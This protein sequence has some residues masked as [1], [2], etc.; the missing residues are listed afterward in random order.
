SPSARLYSLVPRSSQCPSMSTSCSGCDLSQPALASRIFASPGRMSYLSKSKLMS[1]SSGMAT[2]SLGEGRAVGPGVGA[3]VG[4]AVGCGAGSG[5]RVMG[6]AVAGTIAVEAVGAGADACVVAG[7]LAQPP[8]TAAPLNSD[9]TRVREVSM[10]RPPLSI[11]IGAT[12]MG[13]IVSRQSRRPRGT[14]TLT[15]PARDG[16]LLASVG[17]HREDLPVPLTIG[18][19]REM[20]SVGGPGRS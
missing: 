5:P 12:L 16:R 20:T 8:M 10:R 7:R 3:A 11:R 17:E 2:N 13:V 15:S 19:K 4:G 14:C 6:A 1:F 9:T 18:L